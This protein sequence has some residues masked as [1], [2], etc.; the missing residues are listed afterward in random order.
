MIFFTIGN[1][2]RGAFCRLDVRDPY[3][4]RKP[5]R[6]RSSTGRTA[7]ACNS[8]NEAI[9]VTAWPRRK[10]AVSNPARH[11]DSD[12]RSPHRALGALVHPGKRDTWH[13]GLHTREGN[14]FAVLDCRG[15]MISFAAREQRTPRE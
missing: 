3:K 4:S 10:Q 11:H 2:V 14:Y 1:D 8:P 5:R 12:I 13:F 15:R 7:R 9:S 6:P